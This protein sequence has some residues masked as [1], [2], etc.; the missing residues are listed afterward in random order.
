M[1]FLGKNRQSVNRWLVAY[2]LL[3]NPS[4]SGSTAA[5]MAAS[6]DKGEESG[7]TS[8][9]LKVVESQEPLLQFVQFD[10]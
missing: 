10:D 5:N 4:L 1:L 9:T 8:P 2:T 3:R 7:E 6:R